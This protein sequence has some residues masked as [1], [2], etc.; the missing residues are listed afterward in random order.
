MIENMVAVAVSLIIALVMV[1][2]VDKKWGGTDDS[3]QG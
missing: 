2:F 1:Y 3:N